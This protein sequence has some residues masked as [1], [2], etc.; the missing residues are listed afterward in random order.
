MSQ[1]SEKWAK[2]F[3]SFTIFGIILVLINIYWFS[4]DA[5]AY[6]HVR[7]FVTDRM[8][9]S[10]GHTPFLAN[11]YPLKIAAVFFCGIA[12]SV[13]AGK[14]IKESW[15]YIIT[16]LV[17]GLVIFLLPCFNPWFYIGTSIV[18]LYLVNNSINLA[19]LKSKG[20]KN[21]NEDPDDTFDQCR[22]KIETELSINIPTRFRWKGKWNKGWINIIQPQRAVVIMAVPG[23]GKSYGFFEPAIHQWAQKGLP[24]FIYDYKLPALTEVVY[25]EF[26][27]NKKAYEKKNGPENEAKFFVIN[28]K[29]PTRSHRCNPIHKKYLQDTTDA[30][31]AGTIIINNILPNAKESSESFFLP[32]ARLYVATLIWFL[33]LY[34]KGQYCTLPHLIELMSRN[35]I[36]VFSM[37]NKHANDL[38]ALL[39]PFNNALQGHAPEQLLGQIAQAQVPMMS[40]VSKDLWWT[41]SA[42]D[43]EL[44]FNNP[45]HP[46]VLCMGNDPDRQ[47]VYSTALALFT[48]RMFKLINKPTNING[49]KTQPCLVLLDELPTIYLDKLDHLIDT[50]RSNKVCIFLGIQDKSQLT[51]D[52]GEKNAKV[53]LNSVTNVIVGQVKS[54]TAKMVSESLGKHYVKQSSETTG[55]DR[56]TVNTSYHLQDVAQPAR[57]EQMSQGFFAGVVA[58]EAEHPID[59]K[60]FFGKVMIDPKERKKRM[61]QYKPLPITTDRFRA[62]EIEEA[63]MEDPKQ[64]CIDRIYKDIIE[65]EEMRFAMDN[66]YTMYTENGAIEEANRR[67]EAMSKKAK[68]NY[69]KDTIRKAQREE[70]DRILQENYEDI[71]QQVT[72]MFINEGVDENEGLKSNDAGTEE[73]IPEEEGENQQGDEP[74]YEKPSGPVGGD[75]T[76]PE[77]N[78]ESMF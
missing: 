26:L 22:E 63:I 73:T 5:F 75:T 19:T 52:Y 3:M 7:W 10:L 25:N 31:E 1:D 36:A 68:K 23:G 59:K 41:L 20:L 51:R 21:P 32:S 67:Y 27:L 72:E 48:S 38:R 34:D 43:F 55:G 8:M 37:I 65:E 49:D 66:T 47:I 29:D 16:M 40:L 78:A 61:S 11:E 9:L 39:V 44:D 46:E 33:R 53:I 12:S 74:S 35:Y 17:L 62:K 6:M 57:F 56:D 54:D 4:Y 28:F 70:V 69:L 30:I 77:Q 45:D 64:A 14:S 18:G 71:C 60:A 76:S 2:D 15:T 24:M 13:R 58:D 50:A 42:N